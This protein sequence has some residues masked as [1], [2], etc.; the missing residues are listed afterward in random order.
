M[1]HRR[2]LELPVVR[3]RRARYLS[4]LDHYAAA[5][6]GFSRPWRS[7][8]FTSAVGVIADMAD[9]VGHFAF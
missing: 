5:W 1:P 8:W 4:T 2:V 3:D 9:W 7:R 6:A